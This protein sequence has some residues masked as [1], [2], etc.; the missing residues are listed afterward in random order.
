[1]YQDK[2]QLDTAYYFLK[3][4]LAAANRV[5]LTEGY[6]GIYNAL[7]RYYTDLDPDSARFYG[8]KARPF[9]KGVT[10]E[11]EKTLLTLA[12]S[13]KNLNRMDSAYHYLDQYLVIHDSVLNDVRVRQVNELEAIYQTSLKDAQIQNLK[14]QRKAD[15]LTT[16]LL[17]IGII[18]SFITGTFIY[19][20]YR[21]KLRAR[22]REI[23]A[24]N[25]QL[26]NYLRNVLEKSALVEELRSQLEKLAE[27]TG[28]NDQT[29]YLSAMLN[30]SLLTEDDWNEFKRLFEK[31]HPG[32]FATLR[33]H[34]PDL[35]LSEIRLSALIKLN[36]QT[37][38]MASMLGISVDS[39]SKS[40]KRLRKSLNLSPDQDLRQ[41]IDAI[42]GSKAMAA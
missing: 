31:V 34:F 26:Q 4:A 20:F 7:A 16:S 24:K 38:E 8:W 3:E 40:R 6:G 21:M 25:E 29:E 36:L 18:A 11:L 27:Q 19:Y 41:Y 23:E 2:R 42:A 12:K 14:A 37:R 35:T 28:R 1:L 30:A 22:K 5:N 15:K 32:F 9:T 10:R 39:V 33:S 17:T 13:N